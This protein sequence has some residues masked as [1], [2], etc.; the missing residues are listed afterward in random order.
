[1]AGVV[2]QSEEQCLGM[3]G[4]GARAERDRCEQELWISGWACPK[5]RLRGALCAWLEGKSNF[6]GRKWGAFV[7]LI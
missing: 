5:E 7:D 6:G 1:M 2:W 3:C 4:E